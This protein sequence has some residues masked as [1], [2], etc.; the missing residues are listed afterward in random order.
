MGFGEYKFDATS[1]AD[2]VAKHISEHSRV[3]LKPVEDPKRR[4]RLEADPEKWLKYY[5]QATFPRPFDKPHIAIIN[6][7]MHASKTGGR[8]A[9]AGQ[10]GIGKSTVLWGLILM[11]ALSGAQPFPV[12]VPWAASALKRAFRFWRAQL[13][14]NDRLFADYP[15]ICAPFRHSKGSSQK[16]QHTSWRKTGKPT[17]ASL[18]I[19]E[20]LIVLPDNRGCMGGTT[21]NGNPRGLN[22]P[23]PDGRVLRPTIALL[24]DVQDRKTAKSM[25]QVRDT[26]AVIDGDVA[27]MG[28]AGVTMPMLMSGNCIA[29]DDVMAYYL[30]SDRWQ[31]IK[32]PCVEK[33][34]DGWDEGRG[35]IA[36][37]WR[38]WWDLYRD[39][40]GAPSY[41]RVHRKAMIHGMVLSAPGTFKKEIGVTD[42]YCAVMLNYFKMGEEAFNAEC[43][44]NPT[45]QGVTL[46]TLTPAVIQSRLSDRKPGEMPEWLSI[47][48]AATDVNPSYGL[49]WGLTGFGRDQTAAVLGY[50]IHRMTISSGAT[51]AESDQAIFENLVEHGKYLSALPCRP[52]LWFVDAGGAAFDVVLRFCM[53][54]RVSEFKILP[55]PAERLCGIKAMACT[56]RGARNYRPYG[57]SIVGKPKE[58]CHMA[59]DPTRRH[60]IAFNA[61]YWREIAQKAWTGSPGAPGSCTLPAGAHQTFS[62]QIC[63]EQLQGKAEIGGQMV[64]VWN[65]APGPHDYG[66]TMTMCYMGAA[67][68][69]IGST[70]KV[71]TQFRTNRRRSSGGVI[72]L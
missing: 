43:Q 51:K 32:I 7:T 14:F 21:I 56:G 25:S 22:H 23:T 34:P 55:S 62:E 30:A 42:A 50:G 29:P 72:H 6:G 11:L 1:T 57:K 38:E 69:G 10:R 28:E 4:A 52:E 53:P 44:Q 59:V 54:E 67:W 18:A 58:Q 36:Q 33:W 20:G 60:W 31:S 13:C 48:V 3:E 63:R 24:D 65:T 49:T 64:W 17:G 16:L 46:Y 39:G 27:G 8:F 9:V 66:D 47:R 61:D 19:G 45:R 12:C 71:V 35:K 37:L 2:R 40:K 15:E 70:G 41:Y 26:I 5:L 68:G